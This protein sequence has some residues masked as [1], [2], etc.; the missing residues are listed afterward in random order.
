MIGDSNLSAYADSVNKKFKELE[1]LVKGV[2]KT[3]I[4]IN[5]IRNRISIIER[6]LVSSGVAKK[7]RPGSDEITLND[8]KTVRNI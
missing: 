1:A 5:A 7:V 3:Y 8:E 2:D 4:D 6:I